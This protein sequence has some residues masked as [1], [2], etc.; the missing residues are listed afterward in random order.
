M[1]LPVYE[2]SVDTF[3]RCFVMLPVANN[4]L[5][6]RSPF[7]VTVIIMVGARIEDG[8]GGSL[9]NKTNAQVRKVSCIVRAA[10]RQK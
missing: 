1:Y 3:E 6:H 7:S 4:S 8:G 5:R 10:N 9:Y 2:H